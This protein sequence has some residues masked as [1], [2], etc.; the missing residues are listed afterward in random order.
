MNWQAI[1][2]QIE[3]IQ[4]EAVPA[5]LSARD[6][7]KA[8][9]LYNKSL[10][11]IHQG[12]DDIAQISLRRLIADYPE[13]GQASLL[14]GLLMARDGN[15]DNATG[16]LTRA[17]SQGHLPSGAANLAETSLEEVE[18]LKADGTVDI[19]RPDDQPEPVGS[20]LNAATLLQKSRPPAKVRLAS[21]REV[22]KVLQEGEI[23]D[24]ATFVKEAR[25]PVELIRTLV[26]IV[27]I[28]LVSGLL[29]FAAIR[30][31]PPL[32]RN[33]DQS[34]DRQRLEWLVSRLETM[35]ANDPDIEQILSDYQQR[36][37]DESVPA[38][39]IETTV[40]VQTTPP[41]TTSP[42][43]AT[44]APTSTPA[45]T[46]S[47]TP[48]PAQIS[49]AEAA[50]WL[51]T[52]RNETGSLE[53]Q[54]D[55]LLEARTLLQDLPDDLTLPSSDVNAAT[56]RREV[57]D[58]LA[59]ITDDVVDLYREQGRVLFNQADYEA[60]LPYYL[61]AFELDPDN[62]RGGVAYYCGRNYQELGL[63]AQARPYYEYVIETFP[64]RDIA[65]YAAERLRQMGW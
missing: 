23:S 14:A 53:A 34:E 65:V 44:P 26:P 33:T 7:E 11:Q 58:A 27:L 5:F 30:W 4:G 49:L 37:P 29:I 17:I 61:K 42:P 19:D 47:P 51:Q 60:S 52:A 63:F 54:A 28:V 55:A 20:A 43:T 35:A 32:F 22:Q 15:L 64:D 45:P 6:R 1:I 16:Y 3:P 13:F 46:P 38:D 59:P 50:E 18:R 56:L 31:L 9:Y 10:Q 40:P 39:P 25:D 21:D 2:D 12:S 48:D 41:E 36:F 24:Q 62:Y 8:V 57:E